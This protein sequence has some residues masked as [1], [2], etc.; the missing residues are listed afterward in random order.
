M[1]SSCF[2]NLPPL[3]DPARQPSWC[4]SLDT[5]RAMLV[6]VVPLQAYALLADAQKVSVLYFAAG[7]VGLCGGSGFLIWWR[8]CIGAARSHLDLVAGYCPPCC[9]HKNKSGVSSQVWRCRCS[10]ELRSPSA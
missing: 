8:D 3:T 4:C 9:W 1:E 5:W 6:T 10:P 7:T 2:S